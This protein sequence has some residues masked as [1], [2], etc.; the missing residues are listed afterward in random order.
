MNNWERKSSYLLRE[1]V[2]FRTYIDA[3]SSA[4]AAKEKV[5]QEKEQRSKEL[6]DA[7]PARTSDEIMP[8]DTAE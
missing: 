4:C 8:P 1:I 6:T 2:K 3:L 5:F 7:D